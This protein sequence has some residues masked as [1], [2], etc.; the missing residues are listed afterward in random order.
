MKKE[1]ERFRALESEK[2]QAIVQ[3]LVWQ[4]FHI[5]QGIRGSVEMIEEKNAALDGLRADNAQFE[6]EQKAAKK[7]VTKAQKEVGRQDKLVRKREKELDE[8]VRFPFLAFRRR[9]CELMDCERARRGLHW[10]RSRLSWRTRPRSS[11]RPS[12]T[13]PSSNAISRR[14]RPSSL[15]SRRI[16][17]TSRRLPGITMVR[18]PSAYSVFVV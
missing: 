5:E 17:P 2:E 9:G 11:R 3:H 12:R 4:L 7:E 15:D 13:L 6:E 16:S 8:S 1:A 10:T 18:S 14:G